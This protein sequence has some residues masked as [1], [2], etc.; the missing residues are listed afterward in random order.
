MF[1]L[2]VVVAGL[3]DVY[4]RFSDVAR[5][6]SAAVVRRQAELCLALSALDDP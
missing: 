3:A 2:C 5:Y 6:S 4:V 1:P